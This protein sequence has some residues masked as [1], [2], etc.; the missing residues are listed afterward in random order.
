MKQDVSSQKTTARQG[1]ARKQVPSAGLDG[2]AATP[3]AYGKPVLDQAGDTALA[4]AIQCKAGADPAV[5]DAGGGEARERSKGGLPGGLK[6]GIESLSGVAMDEVRVHYNSSRPR[7]LKALAYAQGKDIHLAPGQERHLPHEAWHVVQQAQGRVRPT[8]QMKQGVEINDEPQLEQEA[9]VM[10]ARAM[11]AGAAAGP[12]ATAADSQAGDG[13]GHNALQR[14]AASSAIQ[15]FVIQLFRTTGAQQVTLVANPGDLLGFETLAANTRI[16]IL[17]ADILGMYG[18]NGGPDQWIKVEATTG[19]D[20]GKK[21][22]LHSKDLD[23]NDQ[24]DTAKVTL[25]VATQLFNE[26][27][28]AKFTSSAGNEF[29]IPFSYPI[30]GC[31]ARAHRMAELLTEKGYANEKSFAVAQS[32]RLR[33]PSNK[34]GDVPIGAA[35]V[36]QWGYHVAPVITLDTDEKYVIDPSMFSTPVPLATWVGGMGNI[37]DFTQRKLSDLQA[38][39]TA[40]TIS[41]TEDRYYL[42]P[43]Q[44]YFPMEHSGDLPG[45]EGDVQ[46]NKSGPGALGRDRLASYATENEPVHIL[47]SKFRSVLASAASI[48]DKATQLHT[49]FTGA[50]AKAQGQFPIQFPNLN[51]QYLAILLGSAIIGILVQLKTGDE[52]YALVSTEYKAAA[53][54]IAAVLNQ[55]Y[56]QVIKDMDTAIGSKNSIMLRFDWK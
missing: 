36:V 9:D 19:P 23:G 21:G 42:T 34:A 46:W 29:E 51:K 55:L 27:S 28:T 22:W 24:P 2:L 39:R 35:P 13:G 40:G 50:T 49:L 54:G 16:K 38:E 6:A 18:D 30:D 11:A 52:K 1:G 4:P 25:A 41:K 8:A 14:L 43:K 48:T 31:Y 12:T 56:P 7:Q 10:G 20:M 17:E 37:A 26:L 44:Q 33:V 45:N 53:P 15:M 32:R 5:H 3:P 47:A